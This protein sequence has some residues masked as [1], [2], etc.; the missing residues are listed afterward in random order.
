MN[1]KP[2]YNVYW[3][4]ERGR[5]RIEKFDELGCLVASRGLEIQMQATL[6]NIFHS[7]WFV[8]LPN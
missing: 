1:Y 8:S 4:A 7:S 6:F 2:A 5:S 3:P